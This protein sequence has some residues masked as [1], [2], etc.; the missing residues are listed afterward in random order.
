MRDLFHDVKLFTLLLSWSIFAACKDCLN[1]NHDE[2]D[3][4]IEYVDKLPDY[5]T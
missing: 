3:K 5:K 2:Y 1:G 4:L